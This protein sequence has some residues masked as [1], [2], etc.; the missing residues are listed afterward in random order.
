MRQSLG[1]WVRVFLVLLSSRLKFSE[2]FFISSPETILA[3]WHHTWWLLLYFQGFCHFQTKFK[4]LILLRRSFY[5]FVHSLTLATLIMH[6][7]IWYLQSNFMSYLQ[8]IEM[9][10]HNWGYVTLSNPTTGFFISS[11][12]FLYYKH[13]RL[14][15]IAY[16][17]YIYC[18]MGSVA[19]Q[20]L[21]YKWAVLINKTKQ[22]NNSKS[23][24]INILQ[25]EEIRTWFNHVTRRK[26]NCYV[27]EILDM[28][29]LPSYS[30]YWPTLCVLA[31]DKGM[32]FPLL[33]RGRKFR[34]N[35][36]EGR[37]GGIW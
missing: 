31:M 8:I 34:K 20:S 33:G 27:S 16:I 35:S 1:V 15:P 6:T 3:P 25:E 37:H 10:H 19:W 7:H 17:K 13:F 18:S 2:S 23:T 11:S 28:F 14:Y 29:S 26:K 30:L 22:K 32:H 21:G 9:F 12:L 36:W 5:T 24:D 4:A